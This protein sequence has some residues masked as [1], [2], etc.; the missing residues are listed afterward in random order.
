VFSFFRLAA[1]LQGVLKRAIDGNASSTKAFEYGAL[2]PKLADM[3][4][5]IAQGG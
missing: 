2:A 4:D 1:I 3:A 5:E